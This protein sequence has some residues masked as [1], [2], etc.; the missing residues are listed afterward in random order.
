MPLY[1]GTLY[2]REI[3]ICAEL[4]LNVHDDDHNGDAK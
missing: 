3:K 4:D 1:F 2:F